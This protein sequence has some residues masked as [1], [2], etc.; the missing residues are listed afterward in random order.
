MIGKQRT[1]EVS[2]GVQLLLYGHLWKKKI[3]KKANVVI[4]YKR[5][6]V[7]IAASG[8]MFFHVIELRLVT[9]KIIHKSTI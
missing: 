6:M 8:F 2:G 9:V 4:V 1:C 7:L 5:E 3:Q